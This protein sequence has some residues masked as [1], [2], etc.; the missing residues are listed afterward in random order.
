MKTFTEWLQIC[1]FD[2]KGFKVT[3]SDDNK[4]AY[5]KYNWKRVNNF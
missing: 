2:Y 3:F 1:K 4:M 5:F